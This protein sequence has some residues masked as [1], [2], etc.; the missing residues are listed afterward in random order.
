MAHYRPSILLDCDEL[1]S[2]MRK[3]DIQEIWHSHGMQPLEAL[4]FSFQRAV[5]ANSIISDD[6]KVIGMF[7][8][9]EY[10][11]NVGIPWL[12]GSDELPKIAKE[13]IPQSREWLD[14]VNQRYDLL[15]NFVY[16]KNTTSIRW[17]KWLGFSFIRQI[18]DFGVNPAPFIEFARHKGN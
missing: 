8:V 11:P 7:G 5:E 3:Q 15:F 9:G 6:G 12:L 1:A 16:A 10:A 4:V 17:L 18:D 2:T 14:R 13:F